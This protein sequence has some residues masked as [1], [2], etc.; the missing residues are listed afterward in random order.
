MT[1]A[2]RWRQIFK[3]QL[4]M[5]RHYFRIAIRNLGRHKVLT[6]INVLGLSLGLAC[7]CLI[8][9]FAVNEFSYDNWHVKAGRIY[10]VDETF[11]RKDGQT[12]GT[13]GG[14]MPVGPAFKQDFPDVE[15]AV[16]ICASDEKLMKGNNGT[17][18]LDMSFAD[19]GFF[20]MFSFPLLS[21]NPAQVL[22]DPHDIVVTRSKAI[23]LFGTADAVGKTVQVKFDTVYRAF[24]V[25]GVAADLPKNSSVTFDIMGNFDYL[26]VSDSD[27]FQALNN[28][29]RTYG[30]MTWLLLKPGSHLMGDS[31]RLLQF[32]WR[33]MPD[34]LDRWHKEKKVMA[35]YTLQPLLQVH[36]DPTIL[37][38]GVEPTDPANIRI[39]LG[40]AAGILL[41]ASINFTTLAIARSAS[42]AIEV[43]VRKVLGG[44]RSQLV[45]QFLA[46]S[47][48]LSVI[49]TILG[50]LLAIALLPWF[51]ELSDRQLSFSFLEHPQLVWMLAGLTLLVGLLAG[52]YPA[53]VLS[54]FRPVDVLK[55]R[56]RLGGSNYFTRSLVTLQFVLSIGL[57]IGTVIILRQVSFMRNKDLGLIKEN[58]VVV[59][60][61]DVDAAKGY[62]LLRQKLAS[63]PQVA[64]VT[65]SEL[66]LGEG[67]GLMNDMYMFNGVVSSVIVYPV[68]TNFVSVMGLHLLAG[69]AFDPTITS[70]TV[71]N[72]VVNE[73]LVSNYLGVTPAE[74]VGKQFKTLGGGTQQYKTIIGVV[75]DF[76]FERLNRTVRPQLFY[77][78]AQL[79]P[80]DY[81]IH[82]RG[83]DPTATLRTI[84]AFWKGF[85]PDVP[86]RTSFLDEDLGR[87]YKSEIRWGNIIAAAGGISIF[88]ACMGLFGLAALAAIN[89]I[90]EIGIR[91]VL[92]ASGFEIVG[93]LTGDFLRLVVVASLIASPLAWY[94]MNKWLQHFAY[95]I[96]VDGW[97]FALVALAAL[98]I[99][100]ITIG[101]QAW[102]AA[103]INPMENLRTE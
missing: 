39:L 102:R 6:V 90:K 95:R 15:D 81:F 11:V 32:R 89:R 87:F 68:A 22:L 82:L 99:A 67:R 101:V 86:L 79:N 26:L 33:H 64:G 29:H 78:P 70:D 103:R 74:A 4:S 73:T 98:A 30:D 1:V 54:G 3:K 57:I 28:W 84:S 43:G 40:I 37:G 18:R 97:V 88:L 34:E 65:A 59:L 85:A 19:P 42:R 61:R 53:L 7:F 63:D 72:V 49:S 5:L 44:H 96:D 46:E 21:G 16:R 52:C 17:M 80:R 38:P 92:G 51:N 58:T 50:C 91:R 66:G 83:G 10:R 76:N 55:S 25:S 8:L 75:R 48:L 77:V 2:S 100:Y 71:S 56:I 93:L 47:V 69:R 35:R 27:R 60:P 94:V 24:K 12:V 20:T 14:N 13:S 36:T 41:I 45:R 9:V 23:Q 62:E 31:N